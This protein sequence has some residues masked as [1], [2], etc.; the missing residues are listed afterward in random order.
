MKKVVVLLV[1]LISISVSAQRIKGV[2]VDSETNQPIKH[3]HIQIKDKVV[4]T[5]KKGNFSFR[6]PKN[7]DKSFYVTHLSY[8]N[9]ELSFADSK[10]FSIALRKRNI[11]LDEVIVQGDKGQKKLAFEE[12]PEMPSRLYSFA[13][14]MK[15]DKIYVF[16]G[17]KTFST[18][19]YERMLERM[20]TL[21]FDQ[22]QQQGFMPQR[23]TG[24]L[25]PLFLDLLFIPINYMAYNDEVLVYDI[26]KIILE[27]F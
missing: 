5:D 3:A 17:D 23:I 13:S 20:G 2:V 11:I 26:K 1:F 16:G 22:F 15:D 12:L 18:R 25:N 6:A 27:L 19:S 24:F 9:K 21:P 10:E 7:W 4:L 8:E 14:V